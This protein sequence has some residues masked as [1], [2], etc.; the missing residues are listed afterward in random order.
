MDVTLP[1]PRLRPFA[2]P[3][4]YGNDGTMVWWY[5]WQ[6]LYLGGSGRMEM[7]ARTTSPVSGA[8]ELGGKDVNLPCAEYAEQTLQLPK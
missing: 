2:L 1:F 4:H 3:H 8:T 7:S 6:Y 5:D